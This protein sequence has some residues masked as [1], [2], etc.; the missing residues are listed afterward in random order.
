[1][2]QR[3]RNVIKTANKR[4]RD[5]NSESDCGVRTKRKNVQLQQRYPIN[6]QWNNPAVEDSVSIES[7]FKAIENEMSKG[8]PRD[9]IL[10]PLMKSTFSYRR[11]F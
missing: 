11:D 10:L 8:R 3:V 7:H 5:I 1:M 2:I 9:Q 6:T 4:F